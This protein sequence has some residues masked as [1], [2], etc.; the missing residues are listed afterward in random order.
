M[1]VGRKQSLPFMISPLASAT[2]VTRYHRAAVTHIT[3]RHADKSTLHD[4]QRERAQ[5]REPVSRPARGQGGD[6]NELR[7]SRGI[8]LSTSAPS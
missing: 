5:K 2:A 1:Q 8:F 7:T 4:R 6:S 3:D